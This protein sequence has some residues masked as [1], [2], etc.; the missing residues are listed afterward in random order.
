MTIKPKSDDELNAT[1]QNI[2]QNLLDFGF[3]KQVLV[4]SAISYDFYFKVLSV[5][6]TIPLQHFIIRP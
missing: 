5:S 1:A 3:D 2:D 6:L 4:G